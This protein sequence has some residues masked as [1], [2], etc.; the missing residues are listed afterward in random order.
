VLPRSLHESFIQF[1]RSTRFPMSC[2]DMQMYCASITKF[3]IGSSVLVS[4]LRCLISFT[5]EEFSSSYPTDERCRVFLDHFCPFVVDALRRRPSI[6]V[7]NIWHDRSMT[8]AR[9]NRIVCVPGNDHLC[10]PASSIYS[11][12][13]WLS[14]G[15]KHAR[16]TCRP[17]FSR[18]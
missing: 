3:S 7:V 14:L 15:A 4:R 8:V 11:T 10:V 16:I 12:P 5:L 6:M 18:M 2:K 1:Y 17:R 9:R 13:T